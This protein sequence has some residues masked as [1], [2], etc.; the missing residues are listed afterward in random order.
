MEREEKPPNTIAPDEMRTKNGEYYQK[1]RGTT[2]EWSRA[3]KQQRNMN[4]ITRFTVVTLIMPWS[5]PVPEDGPGT[6]CTRLN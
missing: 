2:G 6:H 3:L 4:T 5:I 1:Y